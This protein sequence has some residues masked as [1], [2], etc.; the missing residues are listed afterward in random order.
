MDKCLLWISEKGLFVVYDA[1]YF[2]AEESNKPNKNL[3]MDYSLMLPL[4]SSEF[5]GNVPELRL[6]WRYSGGT[7]TD[8]I[9]KELFL[10]KEAG[11]YSK[12]LLYPSQYS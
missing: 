12:S 3:Q 2:D 9:S 11:S 1:L 7:P 5:D 6:G 4:P 8:F 10:C